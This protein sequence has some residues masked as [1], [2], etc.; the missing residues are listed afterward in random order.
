MNIMPKHEGQAT[1]ASRE[2]QYWHSGA[3]VDVAAP[4]IG[5]LSVS[6][7]ISSI[8]AVEFKLDYGTMPVRCWRRNSTRGKR[9]FMRRS[10]IILQVVLIALPFVIGGSA[11]GVTTGYLQ[12][13][14]NQDRRKLD[15]PQRRR[16]TGSDVSRLRHRRHRGIGHAYKNA[17][18]SAGH[19]GKRFGKNMARGRPLRAGKEFGK[20]M[21]GFG[22]HTGK[23]TARTGKKVGKKVKQAVTP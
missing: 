2:P 4:H 7:C 5:Q 16:R 23:G 9:S 3:S 19:G 22:K 10:T 15:V 18:K 20:G 12:D 13:Q 21:G 6:A 14:N 11:V 1:V 8:L 17:G